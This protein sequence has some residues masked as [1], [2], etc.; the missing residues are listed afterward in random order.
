MPL[1]ILGAAGCGSSEQQS[2][3]PLTIATGKVT[4]DGKP[5]PE[6]ELEFIPTG[7]TRGQGGAAVTNED[8]RYMATT[9]YGESGLTAGEY[10]VVVSKRV[11]PAN[12]HFDT[13]P[14]KSL[15]PADNPYQE[16][17]PPKY[18][19]RLASTLTMSVPA[20]GDALNNFIL[21]T[22]KK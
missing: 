11:L 1:L 22:K 16:S 17:L 3:L 12:V 15:P 9:P 10:K 7:D 8:G 13:P 19:D 20:N 4:L 2:S 5:L 14:D 21:T 18:S 6:A